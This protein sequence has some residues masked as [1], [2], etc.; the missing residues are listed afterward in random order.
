MGLIRCLV[1]G[2]LVLL[3]ALT[4][5]Q[6]RFRGECRHQHCVS[7]KSVLICLCTIVRCMALNCLQ[8][9]RGFCFDFY[10]CQ[11]LH[12]NVGLHVL[13]CWKALRSWTTA[14]CWGFTTWT[15]LRGRGRWRVPRAA[16]MRRGPWPSRRLCILQPWSPSREEPPAEGPSTLMTRECSLTGELAVTVVARR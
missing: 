11:S 13:R 16:A 2:N 12:R 9:F 6:Q 8:C 7:Y 14:C 10:A 5:I 3:M 15:K 1:H 4:F